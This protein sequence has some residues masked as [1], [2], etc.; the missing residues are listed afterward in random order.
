MDFQM[1]KAIYLFNSGSGCAGCAGLVGSGLGVG[2]GV[3]C[4]GLGCSLLGCS[5]LGCSG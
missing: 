3:G 2:A 1:P 4:S 5:V